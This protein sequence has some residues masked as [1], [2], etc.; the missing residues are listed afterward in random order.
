MI[1]APVL[2]LL[3]AAMMRRGAPLFGVTPVL[4]VASLT[5]IAPFG[6]TVDGVQTTTTDPA[7]RPLRDLSYFFVCS[8]PNMGN[9]S[10]GELAGQP[11]NRFVGGPVH[12]FT[13]VTPGTHTIKMWAYDGT[14]MF[15]PSSVTVTI[16]D[17]EVVFAGS[18][19]TV[20]STS[21][22]FTGAPVGANQVTSSDFDAQILSGTVSGSGKRVLFR[23]G[24][25]FNSSVSGAFNSRTNYYVG[26]YGTGADYAIVQEIPAS[27][28][29][30]FSSNSVTAA[31][32]NEYITC[33]GL[34]FTRQ[35]GLGR[36][37]TFTRT[38]TLVTITMV[39]HGLTTGNS[40]F[41][42]FSSITDGAYTVTVLDA[43]NFTVNTAASGTASG[44]VT[45]RGGSGI[46]FGSLPNTVGGTD[47]T[48]GNF[49][50]HRCKSSNISALGLAGG[51]NTV[52]SQCVVENTNEGV[53][54]A[55]GIG[56]WMDEVVRGAVVDSL[57][58]CN[59][60]GEHCIRR[61]GG[62]FCTFTSNTLR[63]PA[64]S[65]SFLT[66]RGWQ[67][68]TDVTKVT[69][70]YNQASYN[71]I[72]GSTNAVGGVF[73]SIDIAPQ[74]TGAFEPIADTIIE[75]NFVYSHNI[76]F[77]F[78]CRVQAARV[79]YRNNA[80]YYGTETTSAFYGVQISAPTTGAAGADDCEFINNSFHSISTAG[81]SAFTK[82]ATAPATNRIYNTVAYAP[83]ATKNG[84]GSG[85]G[86]SLILD[87]GGNII[88]ANNSSDAQIKSTNPLFS[89]ATTTMTGFKL[90]SG[91]PYKN[92]GGDY[93]VRVDGLEYIKGAAPQDAGALNSADKQVDAW[94]L[95]P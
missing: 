24:E 6:L 38:L 35:A 85:S 63:R 36:A 83:N 46:T 48:D 56:I 91:S 19:T 27:V 54:V 29:G 70:R 50:F 67:N 82:Q 21:G 13:L 79:T 49:T 40:V 11:R 15:G 86:P 74:N 30:M 7:I 58:D 68:R 69:S 20:V 88:A 47:Y 4:R 78:N 39:N 81:F 5:G 60:G 28:D 90:Q 73:L 45:R 44:T 62:D 95:V 65:K 31:Q 12:V 18:L 76:N 42:D 41:L 64:V 57:I 17:P 9:N 10:N 80:H 59:N 61:Q 26:T 43:D 37:G 8:D 23:V 53:A 93:K 51:Y 66:I 77:A 22:N 33:T 25:T 89:G 75:G 94:T 52:F 32:N 84:S 71:W 2:S 3:S 92:F 72:D 87:P 14:T 1:L 34:H 16:Q 55:G